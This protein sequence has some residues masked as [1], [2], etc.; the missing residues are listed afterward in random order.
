MARNGKHEETKVNLEEIQA[1]MERDRADLASK[2]LSRLPS[3]STSTSTSS[4][5]STNNSISNFTPRPPTLGLG[6]TLKNQATAPNNSLE[7]NRLKG[8]LIKGGKS[9]QSANG[10]MIGRRYPNGK[11]SNGTEQE[12]EEE[13]DREEDS[14]SAT[15]KKRKSES[16]TSS[17]TTSPSKGK[18]KEETKDPFSMPPPTLSKKEKK[19][20]A[21]EALAQQEEDGDG[22]STMKSVGEAESSM[23]GMTKAQRKKM[24]KKMK[25]ALEKKE[26]KSEEVEES[27]NQVQSNG[28][29]KEKGKEKVNPFTTTTVQE[30]PS[31]SSETIQTS[32]D[33]PTSS[34]STKDT[35]VLSDS[36]AEDS[37]LPSTSQIR[38]SSSPSKTT[39]PTFQTSSSSTLTSSLS[40]AQFRTLNQSLYT[41]PS[42]K[43]V[44]MVK[45]EPKL[46]EAYHQGFRDQTKK[47]PAKPVEIIARKLREGQLH[48][49]SSTLNNN[50]NNDGKKNKGK[51]QKPSDEN[52]VMLEI[53]GKS[54]GRYSKNVLIADLGC[55]EAPLARILSTTSSQ[56]SSNGKSIIL[57]P[58]KVLS[59]DLLPSQ[60]GWVQGADVASRNGVPLPGRNVGVREK[61]MNSL[62]GNKSVKGDDHPT[63]NGVIEESKKKKRKRGNLLL[64]TSTST[65]LSTTKEETRKDSTIQEEEIFEDGGA[66]CDVVVF[67]LCLMG[68]NWIE[69]IR[70]GR[71]ILRTG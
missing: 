20:L 33:Q 65:S 46:M 5:P 7:E 49:Y 21:R 68:T 2:I 23:E 43:A 24:R 34:T 40:G 59:Y 15:I 37:I 22:D 38:E 63:S 48:S 8:R 61:V 1:A 4:T 55:G 11:V 57:F 66:I 45:N 70:E 62:I 56:T 10:E 41:L 13:E 6:A 42:S 27:R 31:K 36:E 69:M 14:R 25:L 51:D 19:R 47:W 16:I 3:T 28:K 9:T 26:E 60:D 12:E 29:G 35:E 71:R 39:L 30:S 50:N 17:T 18:K 52:Q 67:C 54:K 58:L 53:K 32:S 64:S 44:E